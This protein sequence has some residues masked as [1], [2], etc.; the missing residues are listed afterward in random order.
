M[1]RILIQVPTGAGS[2][3]I[4]LRAATDF[5]PEDTINLLGIDANS[6]LDGNQDFRWIDGASFTG[7][8]GDLRFSNGILAGD[9]NGDRKADL[10]IALSGVTKVVWQDDLF[11]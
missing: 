3:T 1:G 10:E 6:R 4:D 5:T 8:A 7:Q 2:A 11:A 9:V